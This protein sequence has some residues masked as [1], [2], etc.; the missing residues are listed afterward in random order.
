MTDIYK[1]PTEQIRDGTATVRTPSLEGAG[2]EP[3]PDEV[4][5]DLLIDQWVETEV[6]PRPAVYVKG[7]WKQK[8]LGR[9]DVLVTSVLDF[10]AEFVGHRHEHLNIEVPVAIEIHTKDSR[11]RMWNLMAE[12]R[13]I[14]LKWILALRPYQSL[15]WDGFKVE[16]EGLYGYFTGTVLIRLTADA[17]PWATMCVTGMESPNLQPDAE[18]N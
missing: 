3:V 6:A 12:V 17:L 5:R 14:V 1:D 10:S 4:V 13:R 18:E 2:N 7:E 16:Y 11:Q 9:N 15:Y 8:D